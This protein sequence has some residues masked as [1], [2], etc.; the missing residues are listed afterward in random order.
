MNAKKVNNIYSEAHTNYTIACI[1]VRVEGGWNFFTTVSCI[2][3]L[4]I[5][6]YWAGVS[7][8]GINNNNK[9]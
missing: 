9:P 1:G 2:K 6:A 4:H 8:N 3:G 7:I 5:G